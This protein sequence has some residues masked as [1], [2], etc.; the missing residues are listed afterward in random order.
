[1]KMFDK[2]INWKLLSGSHDFP[3]PDGGTCINEAAIVAAGFE[4]KK[5]SSAHD[6]PP[7]FSRPIA[8]YAI[9]LNDSM[10]D[11]L[12]QELLIPFVVRLSGTSD[13]KEMEL[14]RAKFMVIAGVQRISSLLCEKAKLHDLAREC[15]EVTTIEE[16]RAIA[17]KIKKA[18]YAAADAAA[19]AYA[20]ADAAAAAAADAAAY[21][22]A[23]AAAAAA[24][25]AAAAAAADADA[26]KTVVD[27]A[28]ELFD[29]LLAIV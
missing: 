11:Q 13:T 14:A 4:Y 17:P 9:R 3:G 23:E 19:Y 22:A 1:M 15:R 28:L 29:S 6:C 24:A 5:I 12:R 27:L 21:A 16:C 8:A 20:A 10:P 26:R 2:I 25:Y 18:T 7:C